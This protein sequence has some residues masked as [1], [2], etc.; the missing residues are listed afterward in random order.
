MVDIVD[1]KTRSRM[2]AGIR[3]RDTKPE[4]QVRRYLHSRGFRYR[5][6]VG[7]LAGKPDI[8][9]PKYRLAIFVHGCF[10]HRHRGCRYATNPEQNREKWATKFRENIERDEKQVR[11]LIGLGWRV[12]VIWECALRSPELDLS[13]LPEHIKNGCGSYAEWP[14]ETSGRDFNC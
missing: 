8:I 3:G 1:S 6:H 13:W 12:L 5:L 10:W 9:L 4:L 14:N 2:M 11:Q 7:T